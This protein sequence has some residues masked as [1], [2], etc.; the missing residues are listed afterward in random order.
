[1]GK[2]YPIKLVRDDIENAVGGGVITYEHADH[3]TH[4]RLLRRKL[5]EEAIEY[6]EDP[7]VEELADVLEV[8]EALAYIDLEISSTDLLKVQKEKKWNRGSFDDGV[9]MSIIKES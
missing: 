5:I 1:M 8:V 4:R 9:V 2:H 7:C 3:E 6:L